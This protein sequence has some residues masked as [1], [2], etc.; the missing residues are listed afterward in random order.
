MDFFEKN[1]LE[2][3]YDQYLSNFFILPDNNGPNLQA[4]TTSAAA[5]ATLTPAEDMSFLTVQNVI[6]NS[7]FA[8]PAEDM[9][10]LHAQNVIENSHLPPPA[11]DLSSLPWQNIIENSHFAP[12]AVDMSLLHAQNVIENSHFAPT[13]EDICCFPRQNIIENSQFAIE[14]DRSEAESTNSF[15]RILENTFRKF[16]TKNTK[17]Q[18]EGGGK[19]KKPYEIIKN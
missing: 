1:L 7:Q 5:A 10:L 8:S 13:A 14:T 19:S 17:N 18:L 3:I 15:K 4:T 12:P 9:S 11:E 2:N 16:E 6:E